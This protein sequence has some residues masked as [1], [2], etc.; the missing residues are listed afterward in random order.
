[1]GNGTVGSSTTA[2][3]FRSCNHN[4]SPANSLSHDSR[5]TTS[6][7]SK[8]ALPPSMPSH[9]PESRAKSFVRI[10]TALVPRQCVDLHTAALLRSS[11]ARGRA[12]QPVRWPGDARFL[13]VP[14]ASARRRKLFKSYK[15]VV[16]YVTT[17]STKW[18]NYCFLLFSDSTAQKMNDPR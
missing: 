4:G 12:A 18:F 14:P 17:C 10:S 7:S 5:V 2:L 3:R 9:S 13:A 6:S 15:G 16:R 8:R 1:V 11:E